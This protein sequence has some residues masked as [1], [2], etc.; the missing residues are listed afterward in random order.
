MR[1]VPSWDQYFMDLAVAVSTRSKDPFTQVGCLIVDKDNHI[2]GT[3]YNGMA[4]G[5]VETPELWERPTKYKHVRHAERNALDHCTRDP[6]K[7]TVY[8]TMYPCPECAEALAAYP[9]SKIY[10]L[11]E[12]YKTEKAA[13]LFRACGIECFQLV[14]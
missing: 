10:Y 5:T 12:R 9:V 4:P 6:Y 14:K 3:G 8:L 13:A 1:K 2:I 11:D 7:A